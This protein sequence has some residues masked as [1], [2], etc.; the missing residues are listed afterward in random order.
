MVDYQKLNE[1]MRLGWSSN[2]LSAATEVVLLFKLGNN[3][4]GKQVIGVV[5]NIIIL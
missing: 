5:K 4:V 1:V 3:E 2:V